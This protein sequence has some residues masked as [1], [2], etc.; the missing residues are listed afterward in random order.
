M[1]NNNG[2]SSSFWKNNSR[3]VLPGRP[4]KDMR[5][6]IMMNKGSKDPQKF[7]FYQ[8][9]VNDAWDE[10]D[11]EFCIMSG[12]SGDWNFLDII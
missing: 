11:D 5:P 8:Q 1:E 10:G 2:G 6:P 4:K 12:I 7:Q 3:A 9:D